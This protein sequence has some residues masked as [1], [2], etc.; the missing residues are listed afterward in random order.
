MRAEGVVYG[1][2]CERNT[3]EWSRCSAVASG[4]PE[5][6]GVDRVET[7]ARRDLDGCAK[8]AVTARA[9]GGGGPGDTNIPVGRFARSARRGNVGKGDEW[10]RSRGANSR[11]S[12]VSVGKGSVEA[13]SSLGGVRGVVLVPEGSLSIS[14]EVLFAN[15][16]D[17]L[18]SRTTEGRSRVRIDA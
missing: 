3:G 6:V 14:E 10:S 16:R 17:I 2:G 5:V 11:R 7:M 13:W 9:P 4:W 8:E 1:C 18:P 12:T 15:L